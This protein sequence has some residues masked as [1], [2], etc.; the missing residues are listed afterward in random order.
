MFKSIIHSR[1]PSVDNFLEIL[2]DQKFDKNKAEKML[3]KINKNY[4]FDD[5]DTLLDK[6][7]RKNKFKAASWIVQQGIEITTRNKDNVSTVRYAIEKGDIIVVD[8]IVKHSDF[9]INQ[10]DEN[11]RSLL[12][13]A[14]ILG[15]DKISE[16][17]INQDIDVNIKDKYK[18][19]VLF[20]A[21][22]YGSM[23]IVDRV[24]SVEGLELNNIDIEGNTVLHQQPVLDNDNLAIK[25]LENGAD[26]TIFNKE[27]YNFL[28]HT[29]LRGDEGKELLDIAISYGCNL[30]VKNTNQNTVLMEVLQSFSKI[31]NTEIERRSELKSVAKK[32]IDGGSDLN[33][34]NKHGETM[35]FSMIRKGDRD[36]CAFVLENR[37]DPNVKNNNQETPLHIAVLK[38]TTFLD[39]IIL[40]IQYGA[41]PTIPNKFR[42]TVPEVLNEVILQLYKLKPISHKEYLP[43]LVST[44]QY[45]IIL[46]EIISLKQ[47]NF[48][49]YDSHGYPLFFLP[50]L[51][52][53]IKTTQLYLSKGFKINTKDKYGNNLFFRYVLNCFENGEYFKEFRDNLVFLLVNKIDIRI[54]NDDGQTI[55]SR[56]ALIPKCNLKLFRKLAEVTKQDYNAVDKEGRTIIHNCVFGKN[57]ELLKIVY[58]V[59]RNTQNISDNNNMLPITYAALFG[60]QEIV[61]E[62]LR[63]NAVVNSGKSISKEIKE[64]YRNYLINLD[65]LLVGIDDKIMIRKINILIEQNSKRF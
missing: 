63:R 23:Q 10:V 45:M 38:G 54:T 27:G 40:L 20:D 32:L 42:H 44:G 56:V 52:G 16:I 1:H 58:G 49:Y 62:L 22:N 24:L 50:F 18:R 2:L 11:G 55:A 8:N 51:Y 15:Y 39:M 19:N 5:G 21:V 26:P 60:Y 9:N 4:K 64:K 31:D 17:L 57:I 7:L 13:D 46:K 41:D 53:D 36:G 12:Q 34:K 30:N 28:T 61:V 14:V 65:N 3:P 59:E 6:C 43:S 48:D 25:L 29:A 35:L 33:E 47:F 37:S